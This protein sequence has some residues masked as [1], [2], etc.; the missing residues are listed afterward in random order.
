MCKYGF[1]FTFWLSQNVKLWQLWSSLELWIKTILNLKFIIYYLP[2]SR[3]CGLNLCF[4]AF[5]KN[6]PINGAASIRW[7]TEGFYYKFKQILRNQ[8]SNIYFYFYQIFSV[9]A[10]LSSNS[11]HSFD[12]SFNAIKTALFNLFS[13]IFFLSHIKEQRQSTT[14]KVSTTTK[15]SLHKTLKTAKSHENMKIVER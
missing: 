5:F 7:K 6:K 12:L 10:T 13:L 2:P 4:Y 15:K 1:K 8:H 11:D 3:G 9:D 14:E